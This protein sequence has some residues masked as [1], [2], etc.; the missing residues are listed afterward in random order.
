MMLVRVPGGTARSEPIPP[1]DGVAPGLSR[2]TT[3][4]DAGEG[5]HPPDRRSVH[6][7]SVDGDRA[8]G[9]LPV[10]TVPGLLFFRGLSARSPGRGSVAV[11]G[12][13]Q[14]PGRRLALWDPRGGWLLL[15]AVL[16]GEGTDPEFSEVRGCPRV[17]LP[18]VPRFP[19]GSL[20]GTARSLRRVRSDSR[21][22]GCVH[23]SGCRGQRRRPHQP[24]GRPAAAAGPEWHRLASD[25]NRFPR[26]LVSHSR[27]PL[28]QG[29]PHRLRAL[30]ADLHDR[31][32]RN[33]QSRL[34]R[35]V[36]EGGELRPYLGLCPA[37]GILGLGGL[38]AAGP[39][40]GGARPRAGPR[41]AGGLARGGKHRALDDRL[42]GSELLRRP[43]LAR[44]AGRAG[45]PPR[46]GAPAHAEGRAPLP[47]HR[48]TR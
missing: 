39:S 17:G 18:D 9:S 36:S 32:E 20:D 21:L 3:R 41:A 25:W 47:Q 16:A 26:S 10:E 23:A 8:G 4:A 24:D 12:A 44:T 31:V 37:A 40:G 45:D 7:S 48:G 13:E 15:E 33:R 27:R 43:L 28:P 29:D 30:P 42:V 35:S 22:G 46:L 38:G 11:R 34:E 2:Y 14:S 19:G 1:I 5:R 6:G